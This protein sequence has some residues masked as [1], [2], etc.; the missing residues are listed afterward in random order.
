MPQLYGGLRCALSLST[1]VPAVLLV[2]TGSYGGRRCVG[3]S[4]QVLQE[5]CCMSF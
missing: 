1:R 4:L 5:A 2:S 3:R